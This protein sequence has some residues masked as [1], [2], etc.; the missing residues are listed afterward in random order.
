MKHIRKF[1]ESD[2]F[3][4]DP[5][6]R[7]SEDDLY[8]VESVFREEVLDVIDDINFVKRSIYDYSGN[9]IV[10]VSAGLVEYS[11]YPYNSKRPSNF[12]VGKTADKVGVMLS[13]PYSI[14]NVFQLDVYNKCLQNF[15]DVLLAAGWLIKG[16][17]LLLKQNHI[18]YM[19]NRKYFNF[20]KKI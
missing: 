7:V 2:E 12:L 15:V 16:E 19:L 1:N 14:T 17:Y 18:P 5:N 8:E 20:S 3:S 10:N 6:L 11:I 13:A 4:S 9:N